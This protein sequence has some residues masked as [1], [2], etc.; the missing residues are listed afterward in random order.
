VNAQVYA[1]KDPPKPATP[2]TLTD[3]QKVEIL[4]VEK[5]QLLLVAQ[6]ERDQKDYDQINQQLVKN[7]ADMQE[8]AKACTQ[9]G[10]FLLDVDKIECVP[11]APDTNVAAPDPPKK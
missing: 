11:A 10:K 7:S 1:K 4:K 5:Q 8:L 9:A 6:Q 3:A 2:P